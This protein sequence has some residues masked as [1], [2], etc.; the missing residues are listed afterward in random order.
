MKGSFGIHSPS[1]VNRYRPRNENK[2]LY[3]DMPYGT[4]GYVVGSRNCPP[5]PDKGF[6]CGVVE[7]VEK[8]PIMQFGRGIG[9]CYH[10]HTGGLRTNPKGIGGSGFQADVVHPD[11]RY[12]FDGG[13]DPD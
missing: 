2:K 6:G 10:H 1:S 7:V 12:Q 8:D 11:G 3:Q 9:L 13:P 5:W 4:P